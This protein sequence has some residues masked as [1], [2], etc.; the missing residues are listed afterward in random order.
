MKDYVTEQ[1]SPYSHRITSAVKNLHT[2]LYKLGSLRG[3]LSDYAVDNK[4]I[5]AT[6]KDG[7][8][9]LTIWSTIADKLVERWLLSSLIYRHKQSEEDLW[10][11][12]SGL[13]IHDTMVFCGNGKVNCNWDYFSNFRSINTLLCFTYDQRE[14]Q[15]IKESNVQ[16]ILNGV[17]FV[18]MT[19]GKLL[20]SE[21]GNFPEGFWKFLPGY[22]NTFHPS[23]GSDGIQLMIHDPDTAPYPELDGIDVAPGMAT[24]I[25]L[26]SK[27]NIR[28]SKPYG[29]CSSENIEGNMMMNSVRERLGH[30]PVEGSGILDSAYTVGRCR[31]TCL[32]RHIWEHCGCLFFSEGLPFIN[33]SLLCGRI[34][35]IVLLNTTNSEIQKCF[36]EKY[37]AN[38]ECIRFLDPLLTDIKCVHEVFQMESYK[39]D[40]EHDRDF[41][42]HCPPPCHARDY[43]MIMGISKWPSPGPETD[44]SYYSIVQEVV[45]PYFSQFNTS[46]TTDVIKYLNDS[47]NKPKIMNN[48]ARV[49]VYI[50][51]LK[52]DRVEQIASYSAVD[53]ISD[54][55]KLLLR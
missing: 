53:L 43:D 50:R 22:E 10:N 21:Y 44:S 30:S 54:I 52:V 35:P 5:N 11:S 3:I 40:K 36:E 6:S 18:F 9:K 4:T 38:D 49:T 20:G 37:I 7:K 42:C 27:E 39:D 28:L 2:L 23:I 15:A 34:D 8:E 33:S 1:K 16:G 32:L 14:G 31:E 13:N 24:T 12:L 25:G 41:Q 29:E 47:N 55:G 17:T 46:L 45:I 19:G 51:S 26:T 48:F